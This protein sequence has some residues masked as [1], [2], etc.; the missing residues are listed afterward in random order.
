MLFR[1][2]HTTKEELGLMM[3]GS[4]DLTE[5]D[6]SKPYGIARDTQIDEATLEAV[7]AAKDVREAEAAL[8]EAEEQVAAARE[9][10]EAAREAAKA[11]AEAARSAENAKGG[12]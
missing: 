9:A 5:K 2:N 1:S 8:A 7:E 10:A 4:L 3:T 6:A 12:E 11:A